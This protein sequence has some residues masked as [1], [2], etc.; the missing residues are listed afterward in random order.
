MVRPHCI[1]PSLSLVTAATALLLACGDSASGTPSD[2]DGADVDASADEE[3]SPFSLRFVYTGGDRVLACGDTLVGQGLDRSNAV[4]V[5]DLRF[6]V[7]DL[8][9]L[10]KDG[11]E[12]PVT[13]DENDFQLDHEA[14]FVSLVDLT[15]NVVGACTPD[16]FPDSEGTKR[17][18]EAVTGTT[19][20]S[21]VESL[22]FNVGVPQAVMKKAIQENTGEG[23]PSPLGDLQW[24][25]S[26]GWRHFALNF[27]LRSAVG[28]PGIGFVHLGSLDCSAAMTDLALS[29]RDHCTYV[30]NPAVALDHFSLA[31]DL[32]TVDIAKILEKLDFVGDLYDGTGNVTGQGPGVACHSM[33]DQPDC[34]SVFEAFGMSIETGKSEASMNR[35][36]GA[37]KR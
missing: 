27:A 21:K 13:L 29:D 23:Q 16:V 2:A 8:R 5:N 1:L 10:D 25:W 14:G 6:F 22:R 9:F 24:P 11:K 4:E 32:V 7:S 17:V 37:A 19:L 28:E 3:P 20:V 30:N 12:L 36:F 31:D 18:H 35:V 15:S 34:L 26:V 33:P